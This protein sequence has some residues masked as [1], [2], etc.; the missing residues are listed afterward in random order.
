MSI[1]LKESALNIGILNE[2]SKIENRVALTPSSISL[3]R[4]KG[5]TIYVQAGAGLKAGYT[6]EEYSSLGA[7]IVF[8]KEE[9]FGRSDIVLNIAPLN[10]EECSLVKKEQVLFGFHHLAV[11]RKSIVEGLLEKKVTMIGYEIVQDADEKLPFIESLSEVAGQLCLVISGHYL[12]TNAEKVYIDSKSACNI[13][14][15]KN[16]LRCSPEPGVVKPENKDA[17]KD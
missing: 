1:R 10:E 6:N 5:H 8:T 12:Q 3:L 2:S 13:T 9:I 17:K 7:S 16:H 15:N 14:I 11:A 4:E